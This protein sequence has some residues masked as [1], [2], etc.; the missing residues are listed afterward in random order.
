MK[1]QTR[2]SCITPQPQ[3]RKPPTPFVEK[4]ANNTIAEGEGQ[5]EINPTL[6]WF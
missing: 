6:H 4:Q 1:L 2:E 3:E 5:T